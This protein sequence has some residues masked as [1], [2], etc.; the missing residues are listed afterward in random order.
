[1]MPKNRI[2]IQFAHPALHK[3]KVNRAMIEAVR[4]LPGVTFRD[5]YEIY[6]DLVIDVKHEQ[7]LL[8]LHDLVLFQHPFYWYSAP[9]ILKEWCDLVLEWGF[10]YG[11][12]GDELRGKAWMH[13]LTT[14]GPEQAYDPKGYNRF[15][16]RQLLSPWDQTAHLCGMHFLAPYIEYGVLGLDSNEQ[17]PRLAQRYKTL[18]ETLR[19]TSMPWA[20]LTTGESI[21]ER[22]VS[23]ARR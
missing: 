12:G 15:T 21:S 9:S 4:H 1:M 16:V 22:L 10:A 18:I 7:Q 14:G 8:R 23:V 13:A 11:D 19:D 5:L 6:P 3:S 20:Q 2:L 17:I